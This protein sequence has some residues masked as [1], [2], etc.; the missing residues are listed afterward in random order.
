MANLEDR[1][2]KTLKKRGGMTNMDLREVLFNGEEYYVS[3]LDRALQK[4]RKNGDI[5]Y[6]K[7]AWMTTDRKV[8]RHCKGTG[9]LP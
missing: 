7:R 3:E 9:Y 2:L 1:I 8:C 5:K 6:E 4:L